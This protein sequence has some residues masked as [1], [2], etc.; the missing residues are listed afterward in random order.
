ME[1][2]FYDSLEPEEQDAFINYSNSM[3]D[4]ASLFK[5]SNNNSRFSQTDGSGMRFKR[6]KKEAEKENDM[7]ASIFGVGNLLAPTK[8]KTVSCKIVPTK[9]VGLSKVEQVYEKPKDRRLL[10]RAANSDLLE[11]ENEIEIVSPLK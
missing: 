6:R 9:I 10:R 7:R 1:N 3:K 2:C 8:S 11:A 5:L 4:L